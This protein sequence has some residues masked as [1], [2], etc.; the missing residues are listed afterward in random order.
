MKNIKTLIELQNIDSQIL[1]IK[2]DLDN[3]PKEIAR[4]EDRGNIHPVLGGN[5]PSHQGRIM[6]YLFC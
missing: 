3:K 6:C 2:R 4:L 5:R 1:R